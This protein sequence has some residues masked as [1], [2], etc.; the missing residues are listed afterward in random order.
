MATGLICLKRSLKRIGLKELAFRSLCL[1]IDVYGFAMG[2]LAIRIL[3]LNTA[4]N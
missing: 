4:H 1:G 2:N 3:C